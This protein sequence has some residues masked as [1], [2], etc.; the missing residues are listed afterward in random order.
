MT[1]RVTNGSIAAAVFSALVWAVLSLPAEPAGLRQEVFDSLHRSC[2]ANPV[3]AVLLNFR[4]YDTLLE[5]A[6]LLLA[7]VAVWSLRFVPGSRFAQPGGPLLT[8]LLRFVLPMLL[9]T[10]GYQLW[11][12]AFAPGGAFQGGAL[13]GGAIVLALSGGLIGHRVSRQLGFLRAG[14]VF[15]LA[16][17]VVVGLGVMIPNGRLL[18]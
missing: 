16:V 9:L 12:G 18:E 10:G 4:G 7:I 13:L 15:G 3:T 11:I 5:I 2:V 6:V 1:H 8:E 17:F 14:L